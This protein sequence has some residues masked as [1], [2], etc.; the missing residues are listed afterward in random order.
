[1]PEFGSEQDFQLMQAINRFKGQPVIVSK[2]L[3]ERK[4]D[5]LPLAKAAAPVAPVP[6]ATP[7]FWNQLVAVVAARI[8]CASADDVRR[9]CRSSAVSSRGRSRR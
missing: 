5:I 4:E 2:T 8:A 9:N 7:A 3:V 6:S 1:M